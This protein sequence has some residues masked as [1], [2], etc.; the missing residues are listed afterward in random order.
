MLVAVHRNPLMPTAPGLGWTA[1]EERAEEVV[2]QL[3]DAVAPDARTAVETNRS[4]RRALEQ[5]VRREHRDLLVVG[6]SPK[7][8]GGQLRIG[9]LTRQLL[10]NPPCALAVAPRGFA[11][12]APRQ[13]AR[14]GVGYDD[15]PEA[16]VAM[17]RAGELAVAAGAALRVRAVVDDRFPTAGW[18]DEDS[19]ISGQMWDQIL[20]P[21]LESLRER[22]ARAACATGADF[23]LDVT[24]GPP[25]D[26]LIELSGEVDL[27]LLGSGRRGTVARVLHDSTG[28]ALM[29]NASCPVMVV[30]RPRATHDPP[31]R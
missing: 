1:M 24:F 13:L 17:R 10:G 6:S 31:P 26:S 16:G 3:R 23:E 18:S 20:R 14:I 12:R 2:R 29:G 21:E 5:V 22:T 28:E 25:T 15:S 19:A 27:L 7:A 30:P 9:D 8:P 4:V 11:A